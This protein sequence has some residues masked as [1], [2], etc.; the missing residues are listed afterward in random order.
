M[1]VQIEVPDEYFSEDD[2]QRVLEGLGVP[3]DQI[4]DNAVRNVIL[5]KLGS[6]ALIEYKKMFVQRGLP[7]KAAEVMQERLYF[8]IQGYFDDVLPSEKQVSTIFQLSLTEAKTLLRNTISRNRVDLAEK[9]RC[10][11]RRILEQARSE[12]GKYYMVIQSETIKDEIN[13]HLVQHSPTLHR[14][15]AVRGRAAEYQCP[16]D[17]YRHLAMH[18]EVREG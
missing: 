17:T 4:A 11:I 1:R 9:L 18:F 10:T 16:V 15:M 6:C 7:T 13:T 8:L 3:S 2:V 14:L 12:D 5:A